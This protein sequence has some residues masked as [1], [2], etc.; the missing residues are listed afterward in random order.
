MAYDLGR[1]TNWTQRICIFLFLQIFDPIYIMIPYVLFYISRWHSQEE[2]EWSH[3]P[4]GS[5]R[6]VSHLGQ[7]ASSFH[8]VVTSLPWYVISWEFVCYTYS[9]VKGPRASQR[10]FLCRF[11]QLCISF[12]I[13]PPKWPLAKSLN[14]CG[15]PALGPCHSHS[16]KEQPKFTVP[17]SDD[18]GRKKKIQLSFVI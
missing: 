17:N 9:Q 5:E 4:K 11:S 3:W 8:T 16:G 12:E 15:Y 14:Q 10:A 7:Q 2:T 1:N 6:R 18:W 13:F